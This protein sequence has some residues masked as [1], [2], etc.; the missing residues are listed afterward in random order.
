MRTAVYCATRNLYPD[1]LPAIKSLLINSN[2]ERIFLCIEDDEF[3][4]YI[5][6]CVKVI[7]VS[8][9]TY[10][11]RDGPNFANSWTYMVLM[12]A[13]LHKVFP[14]LDT[15]LSLD[16]DTI[17]HDNASDIFELPIEDSYMAMTKELHKSTDTVSYYN[18][19]VMLLNLKKLRDGKGDE[20]IHALNTKKYPFNEQDCINELCSGHI[21]ELPS[22]Y[23]AN[24]FT[25]ETEAP[26]IIHFAA[27]K[28][29]QNYPIVAKYRNISWKNITSNREY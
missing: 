16:V 3:P 4:Y 29:Y 2:V 26:K 15:I 10:F 28:N 27:L 9:Q 17:V 8:K 12:R 5:P 1:M 13:A 23:N 25:A 18:A 19:G 21:L 14:D 11:R 20:L 7:N 24:A 22:E 6:D